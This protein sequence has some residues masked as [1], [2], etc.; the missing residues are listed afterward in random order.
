MGLFERVLQ[1]VPPDELDEYFA[2]LSQLIPAGAT[3]LLFSHTGHESRRT[4]LK[5]WVH[6]FDQQHAAAKAHGMQLDRLN[7][8][9]TIMEL[10]SQGAHDVS[11]SGRWSKPKCVWGRQSPKISHN[12]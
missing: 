6:D 7:R 2:S 5:S 4:S 3:G 10:R 8:K 11:R 1:H 12:S 9:G